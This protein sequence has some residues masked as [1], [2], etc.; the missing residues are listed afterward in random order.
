[1]RFRVRLKELRSRAEQTAVEHKDEIR[2]TIGK[3]EAAVE[4]QT[5]GKYHDKI[6]KAAA[7]ADAYLENLEVK[8]AQRPRGAADE[9][10]GRQPPPER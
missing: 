9:S 3:A 7:Q 6:E 5:G 10:P 8:E 2:Q 1:M 4:R